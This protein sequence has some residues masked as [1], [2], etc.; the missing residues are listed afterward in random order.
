MGDVNN[1]MITL[2]R[3][4][5]GITQG[6]LADQM[7]VTQSKISKIEGGLLSAS[8]DVIDSLSRALRFPRDYF[9]QRDEI[10]GIGSSLLFHRKRASLPN[11]TLDKIH[12][13]INIRRI[14]LSKLLRSLNLPPCSVK[15]FLLD[16]TTAG[17]VG[18]AAMTRMSWPRGPVDNLT[19]R[20]ESAGVII[21]KCDLG[22]RLIDAIG[23][24]PPGMPPMI[25]V[26][27]D[28]PAD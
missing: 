21:I 27:C 12:A 9:F 1:A 22:T 17:P 7:Q 16:E 28:L 24:W 11:K 26:N 10:Y 14:H 8:E 2:A 20:A 4:F 3:Q 15:R 5:R 18:I 13:M 19:R 23:H 6:E 25:F